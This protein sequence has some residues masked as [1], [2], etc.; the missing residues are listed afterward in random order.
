MHYT[1][2]LLAL[3]TLSLALAA[4]GD[5]KTPV[6]TT[7]K[8]PEPGVVRFNYSGARTGEFR[9]SGRHAVGAPMAA[10]AFLDEDRNEILIIGYKYTSDP[11]YYDDVTFGMEN[12][13]VGTF[14]CATEEACAPF[15][16]H[17]ALPFSGPNAVRFRATSAQITISA[18]TQDSIRGTFQMQMRHAYDLAGPQLSVTKGE[19]SVP[20]MVSP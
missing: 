18:M 17:V 8:R 2:H 13:R 3:A 12:P 11:R 20:I 5:G 9:A 6:D 4:C 10:Y 14:S 19:F 1:R 7:P 15:S 16:T